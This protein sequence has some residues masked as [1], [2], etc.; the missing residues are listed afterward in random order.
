MHNTWRA[1][2]S[3]VWLLALPSCLARKCGQAEINVRSIDGCTSFEHVRLLGHGAAVWLGDALHNHTDLEL[4]DLHHTKIGD[5]DAISLAEGLKNNDNLRRLAMHNNR[6]TD[7]GAVAIAEALKTNRAL[8]LL[9]LSSNAIGDVGAAAL[10]E[11]LRVNRALRR[12]DLYFNLVGDDGA[13]PIAEALEVNSVLRVLHL[14]NNRVG[15]L[16]AVALAKM[17]KVNKGLS[18]LTLLYNKVRNEGALALVEAVRG[19]TSVHSLALGHNPHVIGDATQ[20]LTDLKLDYLTPRKAT[21]TFLMRHNLTDEEGGRVANPSHPDVAMERYDH[22][23]PALHSPYA[24][25][26][27]GLQPHTAAG[28]QQLQAQLADDPDH[29][30][31]HE[32][33]AHLTEAQRHTFTEIVQRKIKEEL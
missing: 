25:A 2:F 31:T 21:A 13:V 12:L 14:D 22:H 1:A 16:T 9:S 5:D 6:I 27:A 33:T 10:G 28:L 20:A 7:V 26:V 8:T 29:L 15:D 18:E 24:A 3:A 17:L 4:L 23:G 32:A 11:A 30:H 19:S